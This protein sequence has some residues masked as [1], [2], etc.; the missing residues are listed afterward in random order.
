MLA[1]SPQEREDEKELLAA[2]PIRFPYRTDPAWRLAIHDL[3]LSPPVVL[4]VRHGR[5]TALLTVPDA[6]DPWRLLTP[7][8]GLEAS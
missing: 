8:F 7:Y 5:V 2:L 1:V 6:G 3:G 4:I